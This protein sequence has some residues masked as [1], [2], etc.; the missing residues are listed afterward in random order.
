MN[1]DQRQKMLDLANETMAYTAENPL[2]PFQ[3]AKQLA[4][5]EIDE[6]TS[7]LEKLMKKFE[8]SEVFNIFG[9]KYIET[10]LLSKEDF[11]KV[12][13]KDIS[14]EEF[15][16]LNPQQKDQVRRQQKKRRELLQRI[17]KSYNLL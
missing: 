5:E 1:E 3:Q 7:E 8:T 4:N 13:N 6:I 16:K 14:E 2:T 12:L 17:A 9:K 11:A 10:I 15:N